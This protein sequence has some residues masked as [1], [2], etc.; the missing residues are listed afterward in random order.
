MVQ[1]WAVE[2]VEEA[3][4]IEKGFLIQQR[5]PR[6]EGAA[7][8]SYH[9]KGTTHLLNITVKVEKLNGRHNHDL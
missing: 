3:D 7:F 2:A 8:E 5:Q 6:N 1:A 4:K 9:R